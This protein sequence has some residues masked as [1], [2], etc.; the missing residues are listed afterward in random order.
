MGQPFLVHDGD[1]RRPHA[2]PD[3]LQPEAGVLLRQTLEHLG[4]DE[5]EDKEL[6]L[7]CEPLVVAVEVLHEGVD[8]VRAD[9]GGHSVVL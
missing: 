9:V 2:Y 5:G 7:G 6:P 3:L 1:E 8:E 4:C